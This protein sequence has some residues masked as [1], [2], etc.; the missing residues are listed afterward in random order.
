MN[1]IIDAS[2]KTLV[3]AHAFLVAMRP[4]PRLMIGLSLGALLM[5]SNFVQT[6]EAQKSN[7]AREQAMRE[8]NLM[9]THEA[10]EPYE[11]KKTGGNLF[12][13]RACMADRGQV[14]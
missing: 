8:C 2:T 10:H 3:D 5:V 7:T 12:V 4:A 13:Y 6:A 9:D 1:R 14:E 11:G